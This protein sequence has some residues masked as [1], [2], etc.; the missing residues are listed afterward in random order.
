MEAL[1][2]SLLA[3]TD[4][5]TI[6]DI[7]HTLGL[8]LVDHLLG[9]LVLLDHLV[10]LS[11]LLLG[12]SQLCHFSLHICLFVGF[13]LLGGSDFGSGPS[14]FAGDLQHVGTDAFGDYE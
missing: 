3:G 9:L 4:V 14:S 8:E 1:H 7:D 11:Q 2:W 12:S 10:E 5:P 13:G 6:I